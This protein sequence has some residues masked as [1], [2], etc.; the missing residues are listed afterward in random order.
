MSQWFSRFWLDQNGAVSAEAWLVTGVLLMGT[1]AALLG[2]AERAGDA[3]QL[4]GSHSHTVA[5]VTDLV[6]PR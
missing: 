5:A 4:F 1:I 3:M 2:L 6:V